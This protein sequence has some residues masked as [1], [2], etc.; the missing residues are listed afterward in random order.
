MTVARMHRAVLFLLLVA[1]LVPRVLA[2]SSPSRVAASIS[3]DGY[4]M[5]TVARNLA[6][7]R[8]LSTAAGTIPTNGVQ[9]LVTFVWAGVHAVTADD[10]AALRGVVLIELLTAVAGAFLVGALARRI[11]GGHRDVESVSRLTA[12]LWFASPIALRHTTNGLET[13]LYAACLAAVLLLDARWRARPS[14]GRSAAIGVVLGLAVLVRN[15]AA[16]LVAAYTLVTLFVPAA[17]GD[18]LGR[19]LSRSVVSG[20]ASMVTASPWLLFNLARFGH[21][22]PISGRSQSLDTAF[23]E[24]LVKVPRVLAE[25]LLAGLPLPDAA[26]VPGP[27]P[28]VIAAVGRRSR[29]RWRGGIAA[30]SASSWT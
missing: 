3:E 25:Y 8:G 23:G 27:W 16:L 22:V 17:A 10:G 1:G 7:G 30:N 15:D 4:L 11:F 14:L 18:G 24:S 13:G 21:I 12:A 5:L 6:D 19:R 2:L 20:L 28:F 26:Q 9:P 29:L